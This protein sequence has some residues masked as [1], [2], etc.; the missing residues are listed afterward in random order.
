MPRLIEFKRAITS[1]MGEPMKI[2]VD[3][4][5]IVAVMEMQEDPEHS[6]LRFAGGRGVIVKGTYAAV[7]QLID[8][9]V[10]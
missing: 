3:P 7:A 5:Q 1:D 2:S 8:P 6:I 10:Q 9:P 4:A